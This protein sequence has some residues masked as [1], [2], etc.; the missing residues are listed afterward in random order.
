MENKNM[1]SRR[2]FIRD[3]IMTVGAFGLAGNA[4]AETLLSPNITMASSKKEKLY[5]NQE[6]KFK[7]V[8]FTD[9]H[10]VYKPNETDQ[11]YDIMSKVLDIEKPDLVM[12][13]GDVVTDNNPAALWKKVTGLAHKRNIPFAVV[14]GNHDSQFDVPRSKLMDIVAGLDGCLN[15]PKP[16]SMADVF[17]ETNQVIPIYHSGDSSKKGFILYL[18]DSNSENDMPNA[19]NHY[20]WIRSSQIEWYIKKS[21]EFTKEN[22]GIPYPAIAFFHIPLL[23]YITA[24]ND[25]QY[26]PIGY[27]LENECTP[28]VNSGLFSAF[29]EC[30]DVKGVFV[31]HD[32]NNDY[33]SFHQGIALGYGQ[34]SGGL[35]TYHSLCKGAR[36]FELTENKEV[37]DTWLRLE[38]GRLLCRATVPSSF[39]N[40]TAKP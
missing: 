20:D 13:T 9:I 7:I 24:Y 37:F 8:Q 30:K 28:P 23:E 39:T 2:D 25:P 17:G 29:V 12:Y 21:K 22:S 6:G 19:T 1:I 15:T 34:F 31:G 26:K 35:N 33:V 3:S 38:T 11:A 32:H 16:K 36:V 10:A 40:S 27:R 14:F 5:F 18:F 4:S